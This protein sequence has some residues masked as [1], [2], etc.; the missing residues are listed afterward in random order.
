M[1][2][3]LDV[4]IGFV[5]VMLAVSLLIMSLTQALASFFALRGVQLKRGL[6]ELLEQVLPDKEKDAARD[7]SLKIVKHSLVTD[8]ATRL[9]SPWKWASTIK[10]EELIP[11]LNA[12]LSDK[13]KALF[14]ETK[15]KLLEDWFDSFMT[16]VSQWYV[17]NTRWITVGLTFVI[18]GLLHFDSG[19]LLKQIQDDSVTRE[20]LSAMSTALLAAAVSNRETVLVATFLRRNDHITA[21]GVVE[22]IW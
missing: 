16:R 6:E 8:A 1:L 11:V 21:N 13:E 3:M 9:G 4:A 7:I 19:Q 15:K 12:V 18:V 5:T 22:L 10:R 17:M 14:D 2:E 20:K